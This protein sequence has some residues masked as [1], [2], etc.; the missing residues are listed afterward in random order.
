MQFFPPIRRKSGESIVPMINVVFLLLIFFLMTASIEPP[1][2]PLDIALPVAKAPQGDRTDRVLHMDAR[3]TLAFDTVTGP[4]ALAEIISEAG[5]VTLRADAALPA[6]A[7][8]RVLADLAARGVT[9]VHLA[10]SEAGQ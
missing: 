9:D 7:L 6:S 1:P 3:G 5:P 2:P 8:A 10:T 4:Q